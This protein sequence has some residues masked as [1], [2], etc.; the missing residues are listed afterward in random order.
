MSKKRAVLFGAAGCLALL[1]AGAVLVRAIVQG[2]RSPVAVAESIESIPEI[3]H[4]FRGWRSGSATYIRIERHRYSQWYIVSN[5]DAA[6][7]THPPPQDRL[8]AV[9]KGGHPEV[10]E[11]VAAVMAELDRDGPEQWSADSYVLQAASDDTYIIVGFDPASRKVWANVRAG[12]RPKSSGAG[13][14]PAK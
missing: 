8:W 9:Y 10:P 11:D 2:Q 13:T 5:A 12:H 7:V 14:L 3:G 4:W 6:V 1:V